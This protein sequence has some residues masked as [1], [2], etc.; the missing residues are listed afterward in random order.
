M[1]RPRLTF[2]GL[3]LL[4]LSHFN[5]QAELMISPT[6]V[7]FSERDRAQEIVLINS[8][9]KPTTYRLEWQQ[10]KALPGGGYANLTQEDTAS[11]PTASQMMRFSPSQVRL[12]P[13]ERQIIKLALRKPKDLKDGEYRSHL[14]FRALPGTQDDKSK[15]GGM[16]MTLN[17]HMSYSLP[18]TVRQGKLDTSI[19][20]A[21]YDFS[22]DK[23][24]NNGRLS[25]TL[26]QAGMNS[27]FGNILAYWAPLTGGAEQMIARVNAYSV[28]PELSQSQ[29]NLVWLDKDFIPSDGRFTLVYEGTGEYRGQIFSKK[30]FTH[31]QDMFISPV[32]P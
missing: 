8:G 11:F 22:Y 3:L 4:L 25:V 24:N 23:N 12:Q 9:K 21:G 20:F 15:A 6:R 32:N 28:Y 2:N 16:T 7:V 14:L 10:K 30:T 18:V 13:G 29:V 26:N 5:A 17:L 1:T 27:S 31:T 19:S